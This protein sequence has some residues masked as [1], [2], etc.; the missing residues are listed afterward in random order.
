MDLVYVVEAL[1]PADEHQGAGTANELQKIANA[2][3]LGRPEFI[4][5][6]VEFHFPNGVPPESRAAVESALIQVVG[7]NWEW[8]YRVHPPRFQ[9]RT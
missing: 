2:A 1:G 7:G 9:L 8:S 5:N 4:E 6:A 3:A